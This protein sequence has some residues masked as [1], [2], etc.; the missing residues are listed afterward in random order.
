M[1]VRA[2]RAGQERTQPQEQPRARTVAL[3][4][5]RPQSEPLLV[6]R[7]EHV[8]PT[9]HQVRAAGLWR[10]A[11]VT[12]ARLDRMGARAHSASQASTRRPR[13]L[14]HAPSVA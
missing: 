13:E 1:A 11:S 5:I 9:P 2:Q 10:T 6:R 12:K 8:L 14:L 7:V 3:I 4:R